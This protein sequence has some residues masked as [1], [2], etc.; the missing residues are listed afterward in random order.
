VPTAGPLERLLSP[1]RAA[2]LAGTTD[3]ERYFAAI[4]SRMDEGATAVE[5]AAVTAAALRDA[6]PGHS[7]NALLLTDRELIAVHASEDVPVPLHEFRASGL[8]AAEL[9]RHHEEGYYLLRSRRTEDGGVLVA[10]SGLDTAGWDALPAESV[11][12][13]DLLTL[14]VETVPLPAEASRLVA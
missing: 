4:R 2:A 11:T 1:A 7:A 13:I 10:S 6:F 5:A 3:S 12:R 9:P 8:P 14:A